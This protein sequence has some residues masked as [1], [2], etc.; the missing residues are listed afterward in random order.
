[1]TAAISLRITDAKARAAY[2]RAPEVMRRHASQGLGRGAEEV[3]REA[4]S[5]APKLFSTLVNSIGVERLDDLHYVVSPKV[6]YARA[7]EEGTGPAAG[8]PRYYPNPDSLQQYIQA[9]PRM[10]GY[11]WARTGSRRR[12]EQHLEVWFRS[13]AM[14]WAIYQRGTKAQPYMAPARAKKE[15][16]VVELMRQSVA[17]GVREVMG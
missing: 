10:R 1:M 9:S 5:L 17:A 8:R 7:V 6:G 13:R 11:A 4:R 16:R 3:A 15:S 14:A 2:R 12:G